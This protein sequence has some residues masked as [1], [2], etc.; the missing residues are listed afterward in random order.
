MCQANDTDSGFTALFDETT[1]SENKKLIDL[2]L[3]ISVEEKGEVII[4]FIILMFSRCTYGKLRDR[5]MA[6]QVDP[7]LQKLPC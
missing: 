2:F 4:S 1:N 6:L 5:F 3:G 7:I